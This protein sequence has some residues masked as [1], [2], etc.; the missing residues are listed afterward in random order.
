MANACDRCDV[1]DEIEVE[2]FIERL[3]NSIRGG[4]EEQCV[5]IRWRSHDHFGADITA[6]ARP[7]LDDESLSE[8]IR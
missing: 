8:P 1:V 4:D 3:I 7:V 6:G 5:A 2:L